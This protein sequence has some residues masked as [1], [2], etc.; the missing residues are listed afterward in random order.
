MTGTGGTFSGNTYTPAAGATTST[1]RYI[2]SLAGCPNDT[3]IATV[4]ITAG[5][6]AGTDG[7]MSICDNSTTAIDLFTIIT[8]E[9]TGGTWTRLTGT[10]EPLVEVLILRQQ[11]HDE[12]V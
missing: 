7:S 5:V 4:N 6:I 3:S 2:V 12:Y 8:G 10:G 1:F 11:G 9:Q